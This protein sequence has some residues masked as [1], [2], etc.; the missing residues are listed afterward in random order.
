MKKLKNQPNIFLISNK[1]ISESFRKETC[2]QK[3]ND[4]AKMFYKEIH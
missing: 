3:I 1:T 2:N 4:G